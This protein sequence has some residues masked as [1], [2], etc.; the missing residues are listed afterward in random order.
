MELSILA[1]Q[2]TVPFGQMPADNPAVRTG[3]FVWVL[4]LRSNVIQLLNP[5]FNR[6]I[7]FV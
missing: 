7:R 2:D 4:C 1:A 5:G 3:C 6:V